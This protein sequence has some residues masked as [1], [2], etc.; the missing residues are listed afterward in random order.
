VVKKMGLSGCDAGP[1]KAKSKQ[2][3]AHH[4]RFARQSQIRQL[5]LVVTR[6]LPPFEQLPAWARAV[7][8]RHPWP[9][10]LRSRRAS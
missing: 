6:D 7:D 4:K 10:V 5:R 8:P 1:V 9:V 2:L 3:P